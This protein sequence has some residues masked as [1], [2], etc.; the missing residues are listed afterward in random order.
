MASASPRL[1]TDPPR[2]VT[3]EPVKASATTPAP[4]LTIVALEHAAAPSLPPSVRIKEPTV[5]PD[6]PIPLEVITRILGREAR[7]A[8]RT[9]Y[10]RALLTAPTLAGVILTQFV[11]AKDGTVRS[12]EVTQGLAPE[13]DAC[14]LVQL[15]QT[16]F[17]RPR[18]GP[19]SVRYPFNFVIER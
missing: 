7:V 6:P 18:G 17:P 16:T 9:C 11:V 19:V 1:P 14:V 5:G 3:A 10:V 2:A 4:G 15:N 13:L 12:A 8:L